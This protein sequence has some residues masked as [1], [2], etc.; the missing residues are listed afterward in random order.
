MPIITSWYSINIADTLMTTSMTFTIRWEHNTWFPL[1]AWNTIWS[2]WVVIWSSWP[3]HSWHF[4]LCHLC[5]Q[6]WCVRV[7]ILKEDAANCGKSTKACE[8][9]HGQWL[10]D[11]SD[12]VAK[13]WWDTGQEIT[14]S[15]SCRRE[16]SREVVPVRHVMDVE[17]ARNSEL[18]E[19]EKDEEQ[20]WS[21]M[22][23]TPG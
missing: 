4:I 1:L 11:L 17:S 2:W 15:H 14:Y 3:M 5:Y 7:R 21:L 16:L 13:N 12:W 22:S 8:H 9:V 6:L 19:Q 10:W 23:K 20:H 18:C